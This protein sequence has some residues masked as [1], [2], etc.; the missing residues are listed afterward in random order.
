[1]F[2]IG[3]FSTASG[4]PV[5]T[6]RFYHEVGLLVPAGVDPHNNY[7]SYD[8]RNL[9]LARVIVALRSMEFK[10]EEIREIL[11]PFGDDG[12]LVSQLERQME[13]L[14]NKVS[15][16]ETLI[17]T[18]GQLIEYEHRVREEEK[19]T[20]T[21]STVEERD[22][23]PVL[24]GGIRM[25]GDY[26]D[27][28]QG[29]AT[30]GKQLG[31]HIAGKPLCLF[32]DGEYREGDANFEPCMPIRNPMEAEGVT[33]HKLPAVHCVTLIHH[34]PY[35][36]LKNSYAKLLKYV[37]QHGYKVTLPT[38]EVYLKGPG[39]VFRGNSKIYVTEIQLPIE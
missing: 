1:M 15:H 12:D 27:C 14:T 2:S 10:L 25:K 31:P 18:I 35:E 29:F 37:K 26:S 39:M 5:R 32:Y 19:M 4:I 22:I 33:V 16:Y 11:S 34:G 20:A 13:T 23:E 30:L 3:E 28:G 8:E 36:E 7:R 38:R 6:L 17:H 9:E 24:V 21:T